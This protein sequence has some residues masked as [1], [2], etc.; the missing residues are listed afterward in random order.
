MPPLG[1]PLEEKGAEDNNKLLDYWTS[2]GSGSAVSRLGLG[3]TVRISNLGNRG[4]STAR[5]A[6]H[7]PGSLRR[8]TTKASSPFQQAEI[9]RP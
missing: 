2:P 1:S 6:G 5:C 4:A 9:V 3:R 8:G 7:L